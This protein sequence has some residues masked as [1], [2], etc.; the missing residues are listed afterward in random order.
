M[1]RFIHRFNLCAVFAVV[2][3][4]TQSAC[5]DSS[6]GPNFVFKDATKPGIAAKVG[7]QEI[8]E[9]ELVGDEQLTYVDIKTKEYEFK[10]DRL[11][12][13]LVDK[14]IG[15]KAKKEGMSLDDYI[16]KKIT[17]GDI[18][19]S[20][21]EYKKFVSE[22]K[23]PEAQITP[24]LKDR[25][26][27]YMKEQKK[28]QLIDKEVAS[29]S[30]SQ[31][32]EVY[33]KKPKLN[34]KFDLAGAPVWG[35]DKAKV[36]VVEFSDFQCP[37]CSKGADVIA[38]LKKKYGKGK[39]KIAFKH[40]PLP[41]HPEAKPASEASMCVN[42]QNPDKFWKFHDIVF[43]KQQNLTPA[44]LETYA[45]EA[46]ADVAQFKQCVESKKYASKIEE[47]LKYGERIGIRSTPTFFVNG[48]MIM[49]AQDVAKFAELID[50]E[51]KATN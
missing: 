1:I 50:A 22:K 44:D 9:E 20:D 32:I 26:M 31:S 11:N 12:K 46:G 34:M 38:E 39:V 14:L 37:Y 23:I 16:N 33:F 28:G 47:D 30:K 45:K 2:A 19:I 43:K 5:T 17:K 40:F 42:E 48:Q 41:N 24:Q 13:V 49:G 25:I 29:L 7:D 10:M 27:A 15:A 36:T 51:L 4:L 35:D 3:L 21:G 6:A 18:K 8:T